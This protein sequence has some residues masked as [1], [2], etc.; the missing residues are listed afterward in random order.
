MRRV[1]QMTLAAALL[2]GVTGCVS[3]E[4]PEKVVIGGG[5]R[6]ERPDSSRVPQT[7]THA[8]ARRELARA[9]DY[10]RRLE[11]ENKVL[12][13]KASERKRERERVKDLLEVCEERLEKCED[14]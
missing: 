5:S 14:D 7:Q 10:M 9:Y 1:W 11:R 2:W 4:V 6:A 3:V 8:E 13:A 12:E